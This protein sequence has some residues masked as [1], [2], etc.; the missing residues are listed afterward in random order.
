MCCERNSG[1]AI[2]FK[3]AAIFRDEAQFSIAPIGAIAITFAPVAVVAE[4]LQIAR[5]GL[6]MRGDAD[7]LNVVDS[8]GC[9]VGG[10]SSATL[11]TPIRSGKGIIAKPL[12][13]LSCVETRG[14]AFGESF[15]RGF[16]LFRLRCHVEQNNGIND[17]T[18]CK[19]P[20]SGQ[21]GLTLAFCFAGSPL[22]P[23]DTAGS[24]FHYRLSE[25]ARLASSLLTSHRAAGASNSQPSNG[26]TLLPSLPCRKP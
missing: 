9:A 2:L 24:C 5:I 12:P 22:P 23:F 15:D 11:A 16:L 17:A 25:K 6:P 8:E 1:S 19:T 14:S 13:Y 21:F 18:L 4:D 26:P 3:G 10:R 7:G 20:E